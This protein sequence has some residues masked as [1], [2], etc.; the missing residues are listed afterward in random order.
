[1]HQFSRT[2]LDITSDD[3]GTYLPDYAF[4]VDHLKAS[5]VR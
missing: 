5:V 1:M 4:K 2:N 3:M